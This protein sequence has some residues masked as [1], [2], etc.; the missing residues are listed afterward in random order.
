MNPQNMGA[1][2]KDTV[3]T[4]EILK[5]VIEDNQLYTSQR[6]RAMYLAIQDFREDVEVDAVRW[7]LPGEPGLTRRS[8]AVV[9]L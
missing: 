6:K 9:T 7:E 8:F 1:F 5:P 2:F 3:L 4:S